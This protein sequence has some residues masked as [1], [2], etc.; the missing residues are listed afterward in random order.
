MALRSS[1][2]LC[3]NRTVAYGVLHLT[4]LQ[5]GHTYRIDVVGKNRAGLWQGQRFRDTEF[6]AP[7]DLEG[8]STPTWTVDL[9]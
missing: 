7:G 9:P 3:Y 4:G 1:E 8:N 2:G 5:D 6:I